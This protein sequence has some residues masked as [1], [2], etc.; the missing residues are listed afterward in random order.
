M[1]K[2]ALLV[3]TSFGLAGCAQSIF[4]SDVSRRTDPVIS[5]LSLCHQRLTQASGRKGARA[6]A[7]GS[8]AETSSVFI[9][10]PC[11]HAEGKFWRRT[12]VVRLDGRGATA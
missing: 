6:H 1:R 10:Q 9:E 2:V 11:A 3:V 8:L 7:L 12:M 5:S 4:S